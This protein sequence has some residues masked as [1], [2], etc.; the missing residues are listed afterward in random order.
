[1]PAAA[2]LAAA[3]T[4][5]EGELLQVPPMVSALKHQ[6]VR[7]YALARR[8]I[9]V[10][11]QPRKVF[12]ERFEIL[13]AAGREVE[14]VVRCARGT[15]VR[16]L[17]EDYAAHFGLPACVTRLRRV[18]VGRFSFDD[19]LPLD[20]DLGEEQLRRH[21]IPMHEALGHLPGWSLP[22]FW[23]RKLRDG[24]SPPWVVMELERPPQAGEIGRI[25][26]AS[27]ELVGLGRAVATTGRADRRWF[28]ALGLEVLRVI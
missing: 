23:V 26:G 22:G 16:T 7:L 14:F 4:G 20:A 6:G 18:Q 13:G 11:R 9:V 19:G 25:L 17:V 2:A 8:G 21:A 28:D 12:V 3:T 24:H 5:F 27:G 1:M 15:Y 10:E